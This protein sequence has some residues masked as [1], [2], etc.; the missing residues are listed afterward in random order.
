MCGNASMLSTLQDD[1]RLLPLQLVGTAT[2]QST[3]REGAFRLYQPQKQEAGRERERERE[4]VRESSADTGLTVLLRHFFMVSEKCSCWRETVHLLS[5]VEKHGA[6]YQ[7]SYRDFSSFTDQSSGISDP[8]T[9]V[10]G[11][12]PT[13]PSDSPERR[14]QKTRRSIPSEYCSF[15]WRERTYQIQDGQQLCS[16]SRCAGCLTH[17]WF[18]R[19]TQRGALRRTCAPLD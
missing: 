13:L 14:Q 15:T 12:S 4:R 2:N 19:E 9:P 7:C 18:R 10:S 16:L 17:F 6:S 8:P 5:A 1:K 3:D 11:P